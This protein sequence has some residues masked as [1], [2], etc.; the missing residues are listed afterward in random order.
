MKIKMESECTIELRAAFLPPEV[1]G[2]CFATFTLYENLSK[3]N[4]FLYENLSGMRRDILEMQT[5]SL[6]GM[7]S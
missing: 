2:V 7:L 6:Q 4:V 3:S 1:F 5:E